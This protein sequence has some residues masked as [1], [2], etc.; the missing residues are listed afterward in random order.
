VLTLVEGLAHLGEHLL[1]GVLEGGDE[2][3]AEGRAEGRRQ[4]L[5][6]RPAQ[7]RTRAR[8]ARIDLHIKQERGEGHDEISRL[9]SGFFN[10]SM[11]S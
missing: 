11:G 8:Q 10:T 1:R 3:L 2:L 7:R 4:G 9:A 6:H 5:T